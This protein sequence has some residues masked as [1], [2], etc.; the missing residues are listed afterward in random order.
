MTAAITLWLGFVISI[1]AITWFGTRKQAVAF[2]VVSVAMGFL[3]AIP[4]GHAAPWQPTNG[5]YK[6]LGARIDVDKAIYI[7]LDADPE[8]RLY[9]LP[10]SS[11]AASELQNAQDSAEASGNGV[12]VAIGGSAPGFAEG[13]ERNR[14]PTK[15]AEPA[16]LVTQ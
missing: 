11:K 15:Q 2:T 8:P 16:P 10:Y 5:Q 6:V 13:T 4:L 9:K 12:V 3:S 7:L 1:A 14:E